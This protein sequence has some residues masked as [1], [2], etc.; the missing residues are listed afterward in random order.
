MSLLWT[1]LN[2]SPKGEIKCVFILGWNLYQDLRNGR[3][4]VEAKHEG[5]GN[6]E[7]KGV[8]LKMTAHVPEDPAKE[9]ASLPLPRVG[10]V[11]LG[12]YKGSVNTRAAPRPAGCSL[13]LSV[14]MASPFPHTPAHPTG[15]LA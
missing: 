15:L 5:G 2:H 1:E 13:L 6:G 8:G 4:E 12:D 7:K 10:S 11:Y 9:A 14:E 3:E